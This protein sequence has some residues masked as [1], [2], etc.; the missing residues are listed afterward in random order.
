MSEDNPGYQAHQPESAPEPLSEAELA[1][2]KGRY[3]VW[4]GLPLMFLSEKNDTWKAAQDIPRLLATL[5]SERER[6]RL[7]DLRI[8]ELEALTNSDDK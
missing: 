5:D 6:S 1:E 7:L 2:C 4:N 8:K 3:A